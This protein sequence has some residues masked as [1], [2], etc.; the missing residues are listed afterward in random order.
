M[1]TR[2]LIFS[3][4][5]TLSLLFLISCRNQFTSQQSFANICEYDS[6]SLLDIETAKGLVNNYKQSLESIERINNTSLSPL[7]YWEKDAR[8][9][10]FSYNDLTKFLCAMKRDIGDGVPQE[11]LGVRIYYGRYPDNSNFR[12]QLENV[13]QQYGHKHCVFFVPTVD[14]KFKNGTF[15]KDFV[16]SV[17]KKSTIFSSKNHGNLVPPDGYTGSAI[18]NDNG[19]IINSLN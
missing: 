10:W 5:L 7:N 14:V 12:G 11:N 18:Y 19:E 17:G 13:D 4:L 2:F 9:S 8:S 3:N 1:K 16:K 15:H 6:E